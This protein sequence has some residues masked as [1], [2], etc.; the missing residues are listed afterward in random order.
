MGLPLKIKSKQ[1]LSKYRVLIEDT[2]VSSDE[3]FSIVEFPEYLGE[4][5]N[6]LR[7][8]VNADVFEPNTQ[9]FIEVLD[10]N[11]NPVYFEIPNHREKDNSRLI[12]IY[13]YG[14]R[15]DK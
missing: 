5:K 11:K 1:N 6:L 2:S 4:G 13:V 8:K 12:S 3:Y 14:D 10:P 7:I 15:T 9:I